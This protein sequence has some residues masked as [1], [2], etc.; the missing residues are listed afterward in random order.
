MNQD[1]L[2]EF[3]DLPKT[4]CWHCGARPGDRTVPERPWSFNGVTMT[5]KSVFTNAAEPADWATGRDIPNLKLTNR[6]D[7]CACGQPTRNDAYGCDDCAGELARTLGDTPWIAE[8]L[9]VTITGQ[10]GK[11]PGV[12][13]RATD[14][15][16]WNVKASAV[17]HQLHEHLATTVRLCTDAHVPHQSPYTAPP[18]DDTTSMSRWLLWRVDGLTL[19]KGFTDVLRTALRIEKAANHVIDRAPDRI[20]LGMCEL[21]KFQL[22]DGAVY[23]KVGEPIGKCRGCGLEYDAEDRRNALEKRLDDHLCTAAEIAELVTYLGIRAK[24]DTVRNR[25]NQ[26]HS[27]K[28]LIAKRIEK[29]GTPR[30]R[31]GDVAPLLS[32]LYDKPKGA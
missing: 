24:R 21:A 10:R 6:G 16:P 32:A 20:F 31:Y 23:V 17:L 19:N 15:L 4:T 26:W 27:R 7:G 11:R 25:V 22:C 1:D 12:T 9:D 28:V 3:S 29:D 13:G 18:T 2:C 30:F 14:G 8:Q 5:R